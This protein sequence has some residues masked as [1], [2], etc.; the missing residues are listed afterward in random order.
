MDEYLS[1]QDILE[2]E[3]EQNQRNSSSITAEEESSASEAGSGFSLGEG[4]DLN[5]QPGQDARRLFMHF[6]SVQGMD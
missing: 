1:W 5:I 2:R 6:F 3:V 4:R